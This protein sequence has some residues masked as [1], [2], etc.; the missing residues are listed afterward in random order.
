M[1]RLLLRLL[2]RTAGT[3][4]FDSRNVFALEKGELRELRRDMQIVFQDPYDSLNRR[5]TI[6]QIIS[7]PMIAQGIKD[8]DARA[9]CVRE[10][11]TLVGLRHELSNRYPH[12]L[13]GGQAQRVGIARALAVNPRF[14]ILD[15]AVSA[16]DVSISAQI[17]NLLRDLQ[18]KLGLTYLFIS[19][20]LSLV[21]YMCDRLAVMYLG[22]IV[23]TGSRDDLFA[24]PQ[25][26]YTHALISAI[27]TPDPMKERARRTVYVADD[28]ES[29]T[30]V[31]DGCRFHPR[32]PVGNSREICRT[33]D[34]DS[35]ELRPGHLSS[36][37]FPQTSES[38]LE[39]VETP[40]S[41]EPP[42]AAR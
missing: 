9:S 18:R 7:M 29:S 5:K 37:H 8:R 25:H 16:V 34:P 21:R 15:E 28:L 19:H 1:A 14:V 4:S 6:T 27:P 2:D 33:V 41:G 39:F 10:L 13:S 32:C 11:L 42:E 22:A 31:P 35:R 12:Q 24:N 17:L 20:D 30:D 40:T 38:I 3:V 26:P 23:E 36:C